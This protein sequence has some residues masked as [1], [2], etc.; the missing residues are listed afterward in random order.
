MNC[1]DLAEEGSCEHGNEPSGSVK[2]WEVLEHLLQ[3]AAS[4]EELSSMELVSVRI[5]VLGPMWLGYL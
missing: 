3:L 4:Q 2:C 5:N 1:I